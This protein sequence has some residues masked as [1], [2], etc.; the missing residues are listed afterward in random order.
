MSRELVNA[1]CATLPSATVSEAFGPGHEVWK[2]GGKIFAI[3]GTVGSGVSVKCPDIET[4][5]LLIEMGVGA[6]A[7]YLHASWVLLLWDQMPDDELRA[8]LTVSYNFMRKSLPKKVQMG[9]G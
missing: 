9:L 5:Q 8:R 1:H 3:V 4:A 2:I 6:K 7:P